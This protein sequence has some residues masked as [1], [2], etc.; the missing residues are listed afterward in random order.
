MIPS[1]LLLAI[2]ALLLGNAYRHRFA[3]PQHLDQ[4]RATLIFVLLLIILL[5]WGNFFQP[6]IEKLR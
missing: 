1:L 5:H 2:L 4:F 6:L 3:T